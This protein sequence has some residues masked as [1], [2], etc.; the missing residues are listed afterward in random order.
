[1]KKFFLFAASC[2]IVGVIVSAYFYFRSPW[3]NTRNAGRSLKLIEYMRNPET[4]RD[5]EIKAGE[6]CQDAPFL[7]PTNG[8]IGFLWDDSFRPGHPHQGLD[9]FSG[10]HA[11]KTK[12][13]AAYDGFLTRLEDW[14][15]TVIIRIPND[16][17]QPGRQIWTYYTHMADTGG[18]SF[19]SPEFP[20]DTHEV[21]VKAGTIL[22]YQG[23][24][25][26][27]P[28]NPTGIHLHFSIVRDDGEGHFLNELEIKNTI[29]PSEYF[30]IDLNANNNQG[31]IPLCSADP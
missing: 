30:Q 28:G 21:F 13:I 17:L 5:W 22:G 16:P 29:D 15:S 8:Y 4:N 9:I 3:G 18:N 27:S 12:V 1:M 31:D 6:S 24:Y 20:P 19:I 26:G 2:V 14:K 25:S 23:N 11:G 7:F 10:T